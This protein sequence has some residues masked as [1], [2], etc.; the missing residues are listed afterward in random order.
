MN[1]A[2]FNAQISNNFFIPSVAFLV[3]TI[4]MR[5]FMLFIFPLSLG[6][7]TLRLG[8]KKGKKHRERAFFPAPDTDRN[9]R[10]FYEHRVPPSSLQF[11]PYRNNTVLSATRDTD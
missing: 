5:I 11:A 1:T 6:G 4:M 3:R 9:G 10:S 8:L 2:R 7:L